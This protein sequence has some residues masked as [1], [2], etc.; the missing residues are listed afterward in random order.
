MPYRT[1]HTGRY[2]FLRWDG[3][4]VADLDGLVDYVA[5]VRRAAQQPLMMFAVIPGHRQPPDAAFRKQVVAR[6]SSM[7]E[8]GDIIH[9][10]VEGT[11]ITASM[12]RAVLTTIRMFVRRRGIGQIYGSL[13]RALRDERVGEAVSLDQLRAAKIIE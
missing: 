7:V 9:A 1:F 5:S 10:I 6:W 13:E 4:A 11:G 3:P 12:N 8:N 2:L